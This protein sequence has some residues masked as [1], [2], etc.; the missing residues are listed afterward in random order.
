MEIKD[1]IYSCQLLICCYHFL[2]LLRVL[3]YLKCGPGY[4]TVLVWNTGTPC[5]NE[6]HRQKRPQ[7]QIR[8][9]PPCSALNWPK[10]HQT[11]KS[12]CA[13]CSGIKNGANHLEHNTTQITLLILF[14]FALNPQSF[15]STSWAPWSKQ[16]VSCGMLTNSCPHTNKL[17]DF[18]TVSMLLSFFVEWFV[19]VSASHGP[20]LR[21]DSSRDFKSDLFQNIIA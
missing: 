4:S 6:M 3:T 16:L 9:Q 10:C 8:L 17:I 19:L 14:H 18:Q 21:L 1:P 7:V 2:W 15:Q 12:P 5:L 11:C 20:S 13:N